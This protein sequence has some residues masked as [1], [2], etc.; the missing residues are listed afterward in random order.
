[1][2]NDAVVIDDESIRPKLCNDN[3]WKYI[4]IIIN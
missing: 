4:I 2:Y 1:M 3:D